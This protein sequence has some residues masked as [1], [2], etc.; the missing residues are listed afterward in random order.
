MSMTQPRLSRARFPVPQASTFRRSST[1][2]RIV[3]TTTMTATTTLTAAMSF[4]M[5]KVT[6]LRVHDLRRP[7]LALEPDHEG[8]PDERGNFEM[9]DSPSLTGCSGVA[10]AISLDSPLISQYKLYIK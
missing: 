9:H 5:R 2:P 10:P 1:A 4:S 6:V 3:A 7:G 8:R